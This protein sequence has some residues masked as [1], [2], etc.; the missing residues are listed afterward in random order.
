MAIGKNKKRLAISL[1]N[2]TIK[3]MDS[4]LPLHKGELTYSNLIEISL[5]YYAK[6]I[7]ARLDEI[8]A[9]LNKGDKINGKN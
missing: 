6:G 7:G 1:H 9:E 4:L 5:Y 2:E 8:N 3:L